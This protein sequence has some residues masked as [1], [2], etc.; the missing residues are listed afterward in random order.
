MKNEILK[1]DRETWETIGQ[2]GEFDYHKANQ[3]RQSEDFMNQTKKLFNYFGLKSDIWEGKTIIDLGA[4]SKLRTKYFQ[5]AEIIAIEPLASKFIDQIEWCDLND[6]KAVYSEPA[7]HL[8]Q[9]CVNKADLLVSINVIDHCY[10]FITIINNVYQYLKADGY[11]F[12]SFDSHDEADEMHPLRLTQ[13]I[14]DSIFEETGFKIEYFS[15]GFGGAIPE[16]TYGHGP[17]ALNYGLKK[18]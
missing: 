6:A 4:G 12:L 2:Q 3:W 14:C 1:S 9:N 10:D 8:I 18:R 13:E 16:N 15:K 7:E 5:N 11:A 17:F